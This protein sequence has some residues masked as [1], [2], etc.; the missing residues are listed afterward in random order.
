MWL[1]IQGRLITMERMISLGMPCENIACCLRDQ[2]GTETI[3]HLFTVGAW[4]TTLWEGI[5]TWLGTN[6]Q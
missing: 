6:V 2:A 5:I 3:H 4:T 1:A